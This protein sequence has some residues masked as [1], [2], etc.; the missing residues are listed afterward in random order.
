MLINLENLKL[1][2][3]RAHQLA[4]VTDVQT[5]VLS[6]KDSHNPLFAPFL[7]RTH[8]RTHIVGYCQYVICTGKQWK[9]VMMLPDSPLNWREMKMQLDCHPHWSYCR[10][11]R[12]KERKGGEV[13]FWREMSLFRVNERC[14][15]RHVTSHQMIERWRLSSV[16]GC[17][18][19]RL[20]ARPDSIR[21]SGSKDELQM[22]FT[23]GRNKVPRP[24]RSLH[25]PKEKKISENRGSRDKSET[26]LWMELQIYYRHLLFSLSG[27]FAQCVNECFKAAT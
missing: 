22:K 26:S 10:Q 18:I 15:H 16:I 27:R 6:D 19:A 17:V 7:H 23:S 3:M 1:L 24:L 5:F 21:L 25:S 20:F 2:F 4:A 13:Y 9:C 12:W 8:T 11:N 14:L